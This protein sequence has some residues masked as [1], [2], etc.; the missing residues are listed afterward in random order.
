MASLETKLA[1]TRGIDNI[2][3]KAKAFRES[4]FAAMSE[5]RKEVDALERLMPA[6]FYPYPTYEDMLFRF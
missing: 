4:V 5:V 1:K 6:D 3:K 2:H